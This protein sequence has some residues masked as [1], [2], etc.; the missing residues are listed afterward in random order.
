MLAA[1]GL[2]TIGA[3]RL[4][5]VRC[6]LMLRSKVGNAWQTTR[7]RRRS[8]HPGRQLEVKLRDGHPIYLRS[9]TQDYKVFREIFVADD[10]RV[11]RCGGWECV[12]DLGANVG[13]FAALASQL[14][15]RVI[16]YEPFPE[17]AR[18]LRVNCAGRAGVELVERAVAGR[19]GTL[20]LFRP[21]QAKHTAVNSAFQASSDFVSEEFDEV[22][23]VTLDQLFATHA[24]ERCDL[25]KIDVEGQEYD[26]L[27]HA[28]D[29]TFARIQRIHGEYHDVLPEDP[30]TRIENFA[31]FLRGKGFVVTFTAMPD[32]SNLGLFFADRPTAGARP[33]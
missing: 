25:L 16:A 14:S 23:A 29:D 24:I 22:A 10:Y 8:R 2:G 15:R 33:A 28:S 18:Q 7:F 6:Y 3:M 26:I 11:A 12:V 27:H 19:P 31:A 20:R 5:D 17:N 13:L 1:T 9:G 30:R 21:R 32:S 4:D